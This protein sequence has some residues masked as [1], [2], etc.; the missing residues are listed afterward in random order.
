MA[1]VSV[2][3]AKAKFSEMLARA[4]QGETQVITSRGKPVAKLVPADAVVL[5]RARRLD[6]DEIDRHIASMPEQAAEASDTVA[7]LRRDY[8]Y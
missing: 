2:A 3:E 8:R 5:P 7:R 1:D 4:K 6:L